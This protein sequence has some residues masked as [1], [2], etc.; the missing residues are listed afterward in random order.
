MGR[1]RKER[2]GRSCLVNQKYQEVFK[3]CSVIIEERVVE[4]QIA[5]I[6]LKTFKGKPFILS[7]HFTE[8]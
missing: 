3:T 8:L 4:N 5:F 2:A 6:I 1:R 7:G